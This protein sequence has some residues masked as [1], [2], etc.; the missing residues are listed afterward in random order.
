MASS[1]Y[2]ETHFLLFEKPAGKCLSYALT[3]SGREMGFSP[4]ECQAVFMILVRFWF[5]SFTLVNII[6]RS[7]WNNPSSNILLTIWQGE[8]K[9]K[10]NIHGQGEQ[11]DKELCNRKEDSENVLVSQRSLRCFALQVI[12]V[13]FKTLHWPWYNTPD[14]SLAHP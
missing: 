11:T 1:Y 3:A 5:Q 7:P 9:T 10:Q 2:N 6:W 8:K 13:C 4:C 14:G 12:R